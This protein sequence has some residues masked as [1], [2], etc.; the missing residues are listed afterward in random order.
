[1]GSGNKQAPGASGQEQNNSVTPYR[2]N[3]WEYLFIASLAIL[4][5][6]L[7]WIAIAN[8][9]ISL[10]LTGVIIVGDLYPFPGAPE[11]CRPI[12]KVQRLAGAMY[13]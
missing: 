2:N 8:I 1:M 5:F 3:I 7:S 12:E 9:R 4:M 6:A 10:V 11:I 13:K